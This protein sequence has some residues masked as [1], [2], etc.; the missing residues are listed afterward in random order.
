MTSA[1]SACW[2]SSSYERQSPWQLD[3]A[4]QIGQLEQELQSSLDQ[5]EQI[6]TGGLGSELESNE[7]CAAARGS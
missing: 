6:E 4:S 5:L 1:P 7:D 3:A 2:N